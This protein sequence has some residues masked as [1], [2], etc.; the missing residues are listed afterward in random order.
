M[1]IIKKGLEILISN[2]F[3]LQEQN[4]CGLSPQRSGR[5]NFHLIRNYL[6]DF[7]QVKPQ[8]CDLFVVYMKHQASSI[9]AS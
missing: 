5:K 4:P 9:G 7:Y 6:P 8:R 1:T 3:L 2:P